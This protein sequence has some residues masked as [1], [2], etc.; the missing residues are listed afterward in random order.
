MK[1]LLFISLLWL[2]TL[3]KSFSIKCYEC[4]SVN[5]TR[6]NDYFNVP[7]PE[8]VVDCDL[9]KNPMELRYKASF[10][11]KMKQKSKCHLQMS[12]LFQLKLIKKIISVYGH[13]RI[14]R[15]CGFIRSNSTK[16][17]T[18]SSLTDSTSSEYCE[19]HDELCNGGKRSVTINNHL[20]LISIL[21]STLSLFAVITK[22]TK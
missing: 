6:C 18:T 1:H 17:C 5:D 11:R 21:I 13:V 22:N 9:R 20:L 2:M 15:S 7:F 3:E 10:C 14:T 16:N 12:I 8:A 4:Q 19:C